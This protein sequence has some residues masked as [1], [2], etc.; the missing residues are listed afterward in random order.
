MMMMM[1]MSE[2][3]DQTNGN[4][5]LDSTNYLKISKRVPLILMTDKARDRRE[6]E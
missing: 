6:Y 1:M 4:L 3:E 5:S 2:D